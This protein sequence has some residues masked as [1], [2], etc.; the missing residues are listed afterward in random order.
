LAGARVS[1]AD[2]SLFQVV[3][4]LSYAYPRAMQRLA[5]RHPRVMDLATRVAARPRIAAYLA[6]PRR[7]AFNEDGIFRHYRALDL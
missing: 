4:G 2:L 5:P 1:Y 3:A 7:I 6:S